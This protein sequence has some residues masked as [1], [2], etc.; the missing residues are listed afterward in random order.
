MPTNYKLPVLLYH[1]VVN[2]NCAIGKHKIYVWEKEFE[3]Q[4]R[5]LHQQNFQCITFEDLQ[6]DPTQNL[7]KKVILT[8]D[9]G[10][11][12][13]FDIAFP[14]LK[15]YGYKAVV[16][17][18]TKTTKNT[19][20]IAEGE[21]AVDL[22]NS[23]QAMEMRNYGIEFGAHTQTHPNLLLCSATAIK[24]EIDGSKKDIENLLDINVTSFSYPFGACN[25]LVKKTTQDAGYTFAVSTNKG[26]PFFSQDHFQIRRIEVTP[27]TSL[28]SFKKKV[29]GYYFSPNTFSLQRFWTKKNLPNF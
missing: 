15:K 18:V 2:Q 29:S 4:M 8:F 17:W 11:V 27:K 13:N 19:W 24:R 7:N 10:Y 21:P 3:R 14:I 6:K 26:A 28:R 23:T 9:D 25:E 5:Y 12:D 1:R 20:G 22:L 16:F